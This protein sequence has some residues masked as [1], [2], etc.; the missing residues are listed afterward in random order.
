[1]PR[2]K[3]GDKVW[4]IHI[5]YADN[6]VL[7]P[8]LIKSPLGKDSQHVTALYR[9]GSTIDARK[10]DLYPSLKEA[11]EAHIKRLLAQLDAVDALE[12]PKGW[13]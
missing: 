7:Q 5:D 4:R 10:A 8:L 3:P 2:F 12:I 13:R 9:N 11:V 6:I 1:M